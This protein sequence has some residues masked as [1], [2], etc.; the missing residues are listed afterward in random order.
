MDLKKQICYVAFVFSDTTRQTIKTTLNEDILHQ[1]GASLRDGY[2][3]DIDHA[4]YVRLRDDAVS[5]ELTDKK[6]E[7]GGDLNGF[8]ARFI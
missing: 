1:Y 7:R 8:A 2:L 4:S 3:Y 6:A 5:V